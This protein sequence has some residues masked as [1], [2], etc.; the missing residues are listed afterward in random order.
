MDI[1]NEIINVVKNWTSDFKIVA[2]Y[3]ENP[4]DFSKGYATVF[5]INSVPQTTVAEEVYADKIVLS[6]LNA[7]LVQFS[8]YKFVSYKNGNITPY[9]A[10]NNLRLMLSSYE[11]IKAFNNFNLDIGP[12][13]SDII[14]DTY[15]DAERNK[16]VNHAHFEV[17]FYVKTY[18][19]IESG[20]FDKIQIKD[21]KYI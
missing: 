2:P 11:A 8:F 9:M 5:Y 4:A 21:N 3:Q 1:V 7:V 18:K 19:E 12:Q 15:R 20:I 6:Q 14:V 16:Y 13:I 17:K 10:A